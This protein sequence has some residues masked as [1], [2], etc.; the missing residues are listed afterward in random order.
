MRCNLAWMADGEYA[1]EFTAMIT[2]VRDWADKQKG[3]D[4]PRKA[5]KDALLKKAGGRVFQTD[6]AF[7]EMQMFENTSDADWNAFQKRARGHVLYFDYEV[8]P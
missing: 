7:E 6:C 5:I 4:H 2:A 8:L 3:W 1:R